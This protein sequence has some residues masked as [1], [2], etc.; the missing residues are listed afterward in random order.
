MTP[1]QCAAL[2]DFAFKMLADPAEWNEDT[3]DAGIAAGLIVSE[4]RTT[5]CGGDECTCRENHDGESEWTCFR[6]AP[7]L[8]GVDQNPESIVLKNG[9]DR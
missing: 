5:F 4:A 3:W 9:G 6:V 2:R 7:W 8:R 1:N